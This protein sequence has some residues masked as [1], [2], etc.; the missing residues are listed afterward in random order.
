MNT[1][2]PADLPEIIANGSQLQ[3]VF[4]NL[5]VNA[6][7]AMLETNNEGNI[8]ITGEQEGD[9]V[10]L[11]FSDDGPGIPQEILG[12]LFDP[13]FTTKE[14]GKGTG[15]GLSISYGIITDH[16]GLINVENND[17]GGATFTIQLPIKSET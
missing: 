15:L 1:H 16:D 13:F 6:E 9:I 4:L 5:V 10:K 3:Q 7:H 17:N 11:S 8:T 2:L 14:E 12:K